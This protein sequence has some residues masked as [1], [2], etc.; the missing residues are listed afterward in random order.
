MGVLIDTDVLIEFEKGRINLSDRISGRE[1]EE[2]FISVITA[3]ELLHGV[4][5]ATD[6]AVRARRTAFVE[7]VLNNI[8]VL[9]IDLS[10]ARAHAQIWAELQ[11]KGIMI[12]LHD[13]WIAAMC[14]ANGYTL[15]TSNIREYRRVQGLMV[16]CWTTK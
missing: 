11:S 4:W 5:R 1:Q 3:S 15:I 13:S 9:P 8:L 2:F 14:I 12:G 16:E 6:A 7:G 10:V